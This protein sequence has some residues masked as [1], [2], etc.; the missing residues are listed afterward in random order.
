MAVKFENALDYLDQLKRRFA[1]R[2]EVYHQFLDVMKDF[3]EQKCA[4]ASF[5]LSCPPQAQLLRN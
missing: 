1:D 2:P 4:S 3:K 5:L